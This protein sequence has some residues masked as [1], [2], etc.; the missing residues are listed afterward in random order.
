MTDKGVIYIIPV[1]HNK[2]FWRSS[3]HCRHKA[4]YS[5]TMGTA[6]MVNKARP[7]KSVSQ[8]NSLVAG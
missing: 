4:V 1:H 6:C 2:L 3:T 7:T 8:N 5:F